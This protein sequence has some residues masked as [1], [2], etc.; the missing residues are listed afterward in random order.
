MGMEEFSVFL[1]LFVALKIPVAAALLLIWWAVR[2]PEPEPAAE[3]D[4]GS[5]R[6]ER[7]RGPKLPTPPR[8]G[9]HSG[10]PLPAPPRVRTVARGRALSR[11]DP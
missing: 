11:R 10:Q 9:P 4:G 8:R 5:R 3:D 1:W 7:E 2:E 6:P